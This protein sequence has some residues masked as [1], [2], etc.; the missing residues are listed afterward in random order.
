MANSTRLNFSSL[1][2]LFALEAKATENKIRKNKRNFIGRISIFYGVS[3]F[4]FFNIP[5]YICNFEYQKYEVS[6]EKTSNKN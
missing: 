3:T 1:P 2:D 4:I 5:G 6:K